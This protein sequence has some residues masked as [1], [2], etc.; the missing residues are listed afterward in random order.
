M[1]IIEHK[2][3]TISSV[4]NHLP[5]T[6]LVGSMGSSAFHLF[7]PLKEHLG[8]RWLATDADVKQAVTF[9]LHTLATDFSCMRYMQWCRGRTDG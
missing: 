4:V 5:V 6:S 9:W 1:E 2:I 7:G 3:I 8:D